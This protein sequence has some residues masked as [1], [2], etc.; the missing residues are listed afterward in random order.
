MRKLILFLVLALAAIAPASSMG[1]TF[2][3]SWYADTASASTCKLIKTGKVF[4]DVTDVYTLTWNATDQIYQVSLDDATFAPDY[5]RIEEGSGNI[6]VEQFYL[7]GAALEGD[8]VE[9]L[10]VRNDGDDVKRG[11]L[12]IRPASGT[13]NSELQIDN[14]STTITLQASDTAGAGTNRILQL[15]ASSVDLQN[16]ASSD[17]IVT[18][19]GQSSTANSAATRSNIDSLKTGGSSGA[20]W[21]SEMNLLEH[22]SRLDDLEGT[23]TFTANDSLFLSGSGGRGRMDL[24]WAFDPSAVN[25]S[26]EHYEVYYSQSALAGYSQSGAAALSSATL[27]QIRGNMSRMGLPDRTATSTTMLTFENWYVI[28]VAIDHTSPTPQAWGSNQ[29]L[30][31]GADS[32]IDNTTPLIGDATSVVDAVEQLANELATVISTG[33]SSTSTGAAAKVWYA[34]NFEGTAGGVPTEI[35]WYRA[36]ASTSPRIYFTFFKDATFN[37]LRMRWQSSHDAA[38]GDGTFYLG[39][40]AGTATKTYTHS[41]TPDTWQDNVLTQDISSLS[42]GVYQGTIS[43]SDGVAATTDTLFMRRVIVESYSE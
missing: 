18:G 19:I 38:S 10:F 42:E 29:V 8:D 35:T 16:Q 39:T 20:G 26:V 28:V 21:S 27:T 30:I 22:E 4:A 24:N 13:T 25:D 15:I 7:T 32:P 3:F 31:T 9:D 33:G 37:T 12:Y 5:Y 14:N 40:T 36:A 6:V 34:S 1:A 11:N 43:L 2:Y 17:I 23:G 41:A